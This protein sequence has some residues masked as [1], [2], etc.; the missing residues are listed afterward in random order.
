MSTCAGKHGNTPVYLFTF[1]NPS[2]SMIYLL[3]E[4]LD[5]L[6]FGVGEVAWPL[7]RDDLRPTYTLIG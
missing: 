2:P 1:F 4:F 3:I 7:I 5:E 6:D